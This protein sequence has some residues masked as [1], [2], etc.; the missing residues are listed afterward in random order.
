[1]MFKLVA[2]NIYYVYFP[3]DNY[4]VRFTFHVVSLL[5]YQN[6][7]IIIT[8]ILLRFVVILGLMFSKCLWI[9]TIKHLVL[10]T[11]CLRAHTEM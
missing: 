9:L 4:G 1:M 8:V 3:F 6:L 11:T 10:Y 2:F 5:L 7:T